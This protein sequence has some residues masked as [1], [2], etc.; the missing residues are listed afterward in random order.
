MEQLLSLLLVLSLTDCRLTFWVNDAVTLITRNFNS[1]QWNL[2]KIANLMENRQI[3]NVINGAQTPTSYL[4]AQAQPLWINW[5]FYTDVHVHIENVLLL[6]QIWF[7]F[8]WCAGNFLH[9][10]LV[11][12]SASLLF[13]GAFTAKQW[14]NLISRAKL[15]YCLLFIERMRYMHKTFYK[16]AE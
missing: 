12:Q 5:L 15:T 11:S 1:M 14:W 9:S 6:L 8:C 2:N 4:Y 10:S 3:H 13:L 7:G 16:H